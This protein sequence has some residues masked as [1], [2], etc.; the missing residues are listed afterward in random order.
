MKNRICLLIAVVILVPALLCGCSLDEEYDV[1]GDLKGMTF[2]NFGN[3]TIEKA[4][5]TTLSDVKWSF[6][7]TPEFDGGTCYKASLTGKF[8]DDGTSVTVNFEVLYKY[9][10]MSS[11]PQEVEA[12]VVSVTVDGKASSDDENI[13]NVLNRLYG[14]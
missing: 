4:V 10:K 8:R 2:E 11:D 3:K 7:G 6:D 14:N 13:L 12:S 1:I 9:K 5:E